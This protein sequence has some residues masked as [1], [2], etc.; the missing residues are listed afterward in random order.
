MKI[1]IRKVGEF[2]WEIPPSYK[3]CMRV[4]AVVFADDYLITKM[5]E[6]LTLEQAAN[7]SCLPGI[8]R[9]SY[10]MPDGHQGYGFP[11]GG[12]AGV[13]VEDGYI[14]PGGVGYDINCLTPDTKVLD[15]HGAWRRIKDLKVGE[16][17]LVNDGRTRIAEVVF[18][19]YRREGRIY[20]IK[21]R[22]GHVIKASH[23]HPVL[24]DEGMV[25]AKDVRRGM[26]L[27]TYPFEGVEYESPPRTLLLGRNDFEGDVAEELERRGLLPL[28][29]D[30]PKLPVIIKLLGYFM[31]NGVFDGEKTR[32]YG[33]GE[34]LEELRKDLGLLG[35]ESSGV[36]ERRGIAEHDD[37]RTEGMEDSVYVP[38]RSLRELLRRLGAPAGD[39]TRT[40]FRVPAWIRRS[41]LWMKRLYLAA[42]FG[43]EMSEPRTINGYNFEQPHVSI[44]K[45]KGLED[46][47]EAFLEDIAGL[48]ED[49]GVEVLGISKEDV[50][51]VV[52]LRLRVSNKPRSLINLWT[53]VGYIYNPLRQRLGLAAVAWLKLKV[54]VV[55]EAVALSHTA[56]SPGTALILLPEGA[57][58]DG[59]FVEGAAHGGVPES[60]AP[61]AF[62]AFEGWVEEN[63][64]GDIVWDVVDDVRVEEYN[65]YVYD[66]TVDDQ[67]HNFIA[68][69]VI[70][71]NCGVRLLRTDLSLGDVKD[72]VK[73]LINAM[74]KNVPSGVGSTGKLKLSFTELDKVLNEGVDWAIEKGFGWRDDEEFIESY[75]RI[76]YADAG[77]V[78]NTAKS[79]GADQL[80]TLGAGNHFL[81]I[82]V[83]DKIYDERLAKSMGIDH[84]G[85]ITVMVHTGSRGLGHQVAS[86][87]L[88]VMERAM[89][90]YGFNPPDRE[91]ASVP[92]NS[93]EGEDYFKA[94]AAAAN[95]A[96][97]NRQIITHWVRESIASVF[98]EDPDKLGLRA[99]YDVAHNIA[100]LEEHEVN[101]KNVKLVVHR[102]GATRAFPPGHPEIPKVYRSIGQPVLIPG[103]MGTASYLMAGIHEGKRTFYSAAHG[104]GRWL[105]RNEA[106]RRSRADAVITKLLNA[107]IYV[108]AMTKDTVVEEMPEAYKDVD[109]VALVSHKVGI[110]V[111]VARMRPLGVVK[112]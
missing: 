87:Y 26:K 30:N 112:G 101:G 21:T 66:I 105:S 109:K 91:L 42:Y 3:G 44:T 43:A 64:E 76:E 71:S 22:S 106:M 16:R 60:R 82:Q 110:A 89:R 95:Y 32:F 59:G 49:F 20:V 24:T 85:Q 40:S 19:F 6:D 28:Y 45:I 41:P 54:R 72:R 25:P 102:K 38:A 75:G 86:D 78:S 93:K 88:G 35:Y 55:G 96:F 50:G 2:E 90:R 53:R 83:V 5:G 12:V 18:R 34:G 37:E 97:T 108:K 61:R 4:P 94:M 74:F 80:G 57:E 14:S 100:K 11:I 47:V 68:N 63:V 56:V 99:I 111:L 84:E 10:V 8:E 62:P 51:S 70:V 81:E 58:R 48:L 92:F 73:E 65:G 77:K 104:A 1:P 13:R 46:D 67:A 9:A 27:A 52:R 39:K 23:D 29:T 69:G 103:S 36:V 31:G 33:D 107:G 79:R 17:V 98:R 15:E 7:V